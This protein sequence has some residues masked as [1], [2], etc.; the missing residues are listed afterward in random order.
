MK[1]VFLALIVAKWLAQLWLEK[2]NRCHVQEHA[3]EI[4]TPFRGMIDEPT[5]KKS[6]AYTLAKSRFEIFELTWGAIVLLVALFSGFPPW[7]YEIFSARFGNSIWAAA[8]FLFSVGVL[9]S[10][11]NLPLEWYAQFRLEEKFGFNTSTPKL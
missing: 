2:L 1:F 8:G 10:I 7:F 5:Y 3:N 11:P 4:P 9:L 6:V